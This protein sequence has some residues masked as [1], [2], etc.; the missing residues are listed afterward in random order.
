MVVGGPM[1][2]NA[3]IDLDYPLVRQNGGLLVFSEDAMEQP[4][5]TAC[6]R[7]GRC[8]N[9]CPMQLSPIAIKKAYKTQDADRLDELMADLCMGCG[10]LLRVPSQQPLAGTSKLTRVIIRAENVSEG[11]T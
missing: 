9:S 7:C 1:M 10:M 5:T 11:L 3:Q 4:T 2:G 8:T 6:I